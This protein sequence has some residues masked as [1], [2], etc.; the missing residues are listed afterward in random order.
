M[1]SIFSPSAH[2]IYIQSALGSNNKCCINHYI[3]NLALEVR[4]L[5]VF[6]PEIELTPL[7]FHFKR[8]KK[9]PRKDS[10]INS[11]VSRPKKKKST[12]G[13]QS[14]SFRVVL[15]KCNTYG[16]NMQVFQFIF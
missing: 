1:N 16:L 3:F 5:R 8:T 6:H 11:S 12:R 13:V 4:I 15:T 7:F 9:A 10:Y 2:V 14:K